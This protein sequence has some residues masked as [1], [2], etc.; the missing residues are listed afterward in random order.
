MGNKYTP[1]FDKKTQ[2]Y[3]FKY[4]QD[5]GHG[6]MAV[7]RKILLEFLDANQISPYSYQKGATV[8]LE[9]DC[10]MPLLYNKIKN[11]GFKINLISVVNA[12]RP[13]QIRSYERYNGE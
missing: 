11:A 8:Y 1:V 2:T 7:K 13:S 9:E 12:D 6:W 10:D 5:A 3:T 4:Y